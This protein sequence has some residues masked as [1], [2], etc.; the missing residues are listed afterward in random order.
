MKLIILLS[1]LT[2]CGYF[3][4]VKPVTQEQRKEEMHNLY[5]DRLAEAQLYPDGWPSKTDCDGAV[6][7]SELSM[8]GA[9]VDLSLAFDEGIAHRT[10]GKDCYETGRSRSIT[11]NDT[12]VMTMVA[13]YIK[14]DSTSLK[15]MMSHGRV[16]GWVYGVELESYLKPWYQSLLYA[17][18]DEPTHMPFILTYSPEDYVAHIQAIAIW[19]YLQAKGEIS[20]SN[21][22]L[23]RRYHQR[24]P[25][26]Y[27]IRSIYGLFHRELNSPFLEIEPPSYVR[28]SEA[29]RFALV[30]WLLAARIYLG[31]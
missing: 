4:T 2:C 25:N 30:H 17:L 9:Y 18:N 3:E 23:L 5:E 29:G 7:A 24:D 15:K 12:M 11:S 20:E 10:P 8:A 31:R 19:G 1:M 13:Y 26:D 27:L 28:G 6:W 16:N 21:L 14:G 22:A